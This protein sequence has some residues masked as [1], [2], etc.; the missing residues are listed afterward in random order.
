MAGSGSK[1]ARKTYGACVPF[2]AGPG[3]LACVCVGAALPVGWLKWLIRHEL[4]VVPWCCSDCTRVA[5]GFRR[6]VDTES[7]TFKYFLKVV[8]TEYADFK[9]A[10]SQQRGLALLKYRLCQ[11]RPCRSV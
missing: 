6:F 4:A 7:G 5:A 1:D 9:G 10:C 8:P 11:C 3:A 2:P